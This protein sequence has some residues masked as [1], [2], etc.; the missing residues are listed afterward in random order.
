[1]YKTCVLRI[2]GTVALVL[3]LLAGSAGLGLQ[4][5]RYNHDRAVRIQR[6]RV[7]AGTA[8]RRQCQR[9]WRMGEAL[10]DQARRQCALRAC[11][12]NP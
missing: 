4:I 11:T 5:S 2:Y 10:D 9:C 3:V 12:E 8:L 1:M 6:F 7:A